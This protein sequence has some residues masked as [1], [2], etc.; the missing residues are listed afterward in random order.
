MKRKALFAAAAAALL[1]V[2]SA[3]ALAQ[4]APPAPSV[5]PAP[6]AELVAPAGAAARVADVVVAP[7]PP[8]PAAQS[9]PPAPVAPPEPADFPEPQVGFAETFFDDG[10]YLG[11][12]VEEVTRENAKTYGLTGEPRGVVVTQV[13]KGSPAERAGLRERDV[14][15]RFDG[16]PVTSVRKLTRLITESS[17]DH[18]ARV[19]VLRGG[20]EQEV[21]AAL[22]RRDRLAPAGA[23][24]GGF[25]LEGAKRL[26]E[27]WGKNAEEWK[28]KADEWGKG[29]E[30][31]QGDGAFV[32]GPS[33]RI[34]VTT[35]TLGK[36]LADYFGVSRGVLVNSVESGGPADKAGLKAG[37]VVTEVDGRAL[38][39]TSDLA[40]SLGAKEEGD[41]TLT[42]VR[43]KK[44][45]TVRVTPERWKTPRSLYMTPGAVKIA[46]PVAALAAPRVSLTPRAWVVPN[47]V[48]APYVLRDP[49]FI[50]PPAVIAAPR[51][52]SAPSRILSAPRIRV[53]PR[54][55]VIAP[56]GRIL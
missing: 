12:R 52:P 42:V 34:G 27:E 4:G 18:T 44:R 23:A 37:D 17:P 56:D 10:N 50:T 30:G 1:S 13:L 6:P 2:A 40:R 25:D 55:T 28:L 49:D 46:P 24:V 41:V 16:E 26:G 15:V 53:A 7:A 11:V 5:A 21:S 31:F 3:N 22:A 8:S 45:R 36:Q 47:V 51:A 35:S 14:I 32:L 19:T 29:L 39:D 33:R 48:A 43:D 9:A 20:S 38:D 54:V